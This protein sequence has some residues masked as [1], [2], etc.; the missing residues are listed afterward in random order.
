MTNLE[1]VRR[2]LS[3]NARQEFAL[4]DLDNKMTRLGYK[5]KANNEYWSICLRCGSIIYTEAEE[6]ANPSVQIF[7][8]IAIPR[9]DLKYTIIK[10]TK[11]EEF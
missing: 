5:S 11:V 9:F 3:K 7:F 6:N 1:R 8:N 10:I 4:Y 2:E